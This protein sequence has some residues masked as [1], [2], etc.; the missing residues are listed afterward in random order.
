LS[1]DRTVLERRSASEWRIDDSATVIGRGID[2]FERA[3]I[4]L[5]TWRQFDIGWAHLYPADAPVVSGTVVVVLTW[6]LGF[7]S[8][9]GCRVLEVI[10]QPAKRFGF[11]YGT[12]MNHVVRGEELFEVVVDA[13]EAIV[14]HVRAVSQPQALV[15]RLGAPIA[16][17]IQAR[18]R[19]DSAEA[20]TRASAGNTP[21]P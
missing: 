14:Y 9:S 10:D 2:V 19:R 3:R 20:L 13:S 21:T 12:L 5:S 4:A 15:A 1:Y 17:R 16:A 11:I 18:F 6:H 7:W 8:L